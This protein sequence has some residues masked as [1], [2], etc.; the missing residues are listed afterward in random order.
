[1]ILVTGGAGYIGSHAVINFLD[2]GYDILIFDNLE[3][4]HIETIETL[5]NIG[6]VKF[7]KGDL[8]NIHDLERIFCE[9]KIDGVIHF[10][11]Y[12]LVE[13]SVK[14]P[15]KYYENNVVGTL[16]LLNTMIK[17]NVKQI[18]FSST[19]ATYGEPNYVPVDEKHPQNP[20]NPYG[21]S[22]LMME[23]IMDDYDKAYDLKSIKL[24]YFNVVG[25]DSNNRIGEWHDIETHLVPNIL[26]SALYE[27]KEFKIFGDD[28]NTKD[29]TCIRDYTN[30]EDLAFAHRLAFEYLLKENKS[31]VFN[32][33]TQNG[34]SVKEVFETCQQVVNKKINYKIE[35]KRPGDPAMLYADTSKICQIL[36]WKPNRTLKHS[37]KTSYEWEKKNEQRK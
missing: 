37:I 34:S 4:G 28:Y 30:V 14:N 18:V 27:S 15:A 17:H 23:K 2:A 32:I 20:I 26:K 22:K 29:G 7:E 16:N 11:A 9:Y 3:V 33:G 19:C 35:N 12:A 36:N 8:R 1:M 5:K 21:N 31:D 6:N 25:A 24:R 13:E 10:A